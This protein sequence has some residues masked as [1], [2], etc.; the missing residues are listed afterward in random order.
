[1]LAAT[2]EIAG[3]SF[4][5][6]VILGDA[7]R[8]RRE[9]KRRPGLVTRPDDRS[10][11]TPLHAVCGSQ[12]H[13]LDPARADGLL[14]VARLLLDAGTD[15]AAKKGGRPGDWTPLRC[16]VADTARLGY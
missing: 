15:P 3:D 13:R 9:I 7:S 10:G 5:T 8:V 4:A 14:A 6:A 1:M 12:W 16:A 2:P 11:W